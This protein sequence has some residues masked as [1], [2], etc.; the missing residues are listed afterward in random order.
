MFD[1][2]RVQGLKE[3]YVLLGFY[4]HLTTNFI[5]PGFFKWG[6]S[7]IPLALELPSPN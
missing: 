2:P 7:S 1:V 6:N 4:A 3:L 5:N